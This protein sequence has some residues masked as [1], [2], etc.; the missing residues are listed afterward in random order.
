MVH[1]VFNDDT[2]CSLVCFCCAQIYTSWIGKKIIRNNIGT[3]KSPIA[4]VSGAYAIEDLIGS[5]DVRKLCFED[6]VFKERYA[7]EN[8]SLSKEAYLQED[9]WEWRRKLRY[10]NGM[11]VSV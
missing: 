4:M 9:C 3:L 8:S 5:S 11:E 2:I 10:A 6:V 1:S 7:K